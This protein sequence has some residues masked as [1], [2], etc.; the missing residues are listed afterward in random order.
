MLNKIEIRNFKTLRNQT[1]DL[2]PLTIFVGP[3]GAGKSSI[4]E[5]IALMAQAAEINNIFPNAL[6]GELVDFERPDDVIT[7]GAENLRLFLGFQ[8]DADVDLLLYSLNEDLKALDGFLSRNPIVE[9]PE[10]EKIQKNRL[11][12]LPRFR[13][14]LLSTKEILISSKR[15]EAPIRFRFV[16]N[17]KST[18]SSHTLWVASKQLVKVTQ[19]TTTQAYSTGELRAENWLQFLPNLYFDQFQSRLLKLIHELLKNSLQKVRYLLADRGSIPWVYNPDT[20]TKFQWVGRK[21][22]NTLEILADLISP[23][24][25]EAKL[26]YELFFE[27]FGMK[28]VW[29]GWMFP[30]SLTSGYVDPFFNSVHKLPSLGYGSKQLLTVIVQLAHA[31]KGSIILVEEP[32]VSLHPAYQS[33][34]PALFGKAVL[35]GKQVIVT[36]HSSYFPLSLD[37]IFKGYV[38]EGQTTGGQQKYT[39]KISPKEVAVYHVSRIAEGP[40]KIDK[41]E[42]DEN[43]LKEGIPS[44]IEVERQILSRFI[45]QG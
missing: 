11:T 1:I 38:L 4:L 10:I 41:L 7:K 35:E 39:I 30:N 27:K 29:A 16:S 25:H 22:Q 18:Y 45:K 8:I 15:K 33:L 36:S 43:G 5:S 40:S 17:I 24:Y 9:M 42:I 34:L 20:S 13:E 3:N 26:P 32:E 44:F 21:G 31:S 2:A 12:D 28:E 19:G 23:K 37:S 6:K 14:R